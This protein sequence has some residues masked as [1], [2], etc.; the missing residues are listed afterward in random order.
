MIHCELI[1]RKS[2]RSEG[3]GSAGD[4]AFLLLLLLFLASLALYFGYK[5]SKCPS[6]KVQLHYCSF[7]SFFF[8]FFFFFIY[9]Y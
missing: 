2:I 8:F 4:R 9:F 6:L 1:F 7:N 3:E 5:F